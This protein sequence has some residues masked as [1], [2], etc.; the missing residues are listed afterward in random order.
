MIA[1]AKQTLRRSLAADLDEILEME[2]QAQLRAF[3]SD[4]F[5]EGVRAFLEKRSPRF[6]A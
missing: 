3:G 5:T 4:D 1:D 6:G 2:K